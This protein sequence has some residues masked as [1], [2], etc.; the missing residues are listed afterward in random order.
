M[1]STEQDNE[2]KQLDRK[3]SKKIVEKASEIE[4]KKAKLRDELDER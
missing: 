2:I 4:F 1:K 3:D